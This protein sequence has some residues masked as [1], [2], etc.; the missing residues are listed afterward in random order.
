MMSQYL[1]AVGTKREA[2]FRRHPLPGS[3]LRRLAV[4]AAALA[5][6]GLVAVRASAQQ[7]LQQPSQAQS[8][9]VAADA[10]RAAAVPLVTYEQ[11]KLTIVAENASLSDVMAA[12]H[13]AM[14]TEV[15]I[16][17]GSA[18]ERIWAHLGPGSAQK[19]LS[20]LFANTDLDY[21][22]QGSATDAGAIRSVALSVR[23]PDS[24]PGKNGPT[25][26][27]IE[28]AARRRFGSAPA[29]EPEPEATPAPAPTA[30]PQEASAAA[31]AAPSAPPATDAASSSSDSA[32]APTEPPADVTP[33]VAEQASMT[34]TGPPNVFPQ[35]PQPSAGS[36]NPHPSPPASM[37]TDQMVQQ[38][39]N[40][41]QQ[42]R[43]M[44]QGQA[45]S[46]PN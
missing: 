29:P 4:F 18:T 6:T 43:Q 9:P 39:T 41:Y 28:S 25:S 35:T 44:Q 27:P 46:T 26:S 14:G 2:S 34:P 38:L 42:R 21:I 37:S 5:A 16:P 12:L 45:G 24:S 23:A 13:S 31:L 32:S 7:G 17:A 10:P 1:G 30:A 15:D 11:G 19:I 3:G 40:M 33:K 22:V 36:F 20:D 8:A